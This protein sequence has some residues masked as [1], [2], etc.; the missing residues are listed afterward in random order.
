MI[1]SELDEKVENF[2]HNLKKGKNISL[3]NEK[4]TK[5]LKKII[6][7]DITLKI[8]FDKIIRHYEKNIYFYRNYCLKI[9][10]Y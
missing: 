8:V 1:L 2:K 9:K 3:I 6:S 5:D 4:A 10:K 7:K